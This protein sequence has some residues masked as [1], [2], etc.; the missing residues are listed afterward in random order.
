MK[1]LIS[2]IS[3]LV[4]ILSL[5]ACSGGGGGS[6]SKAIDGEWVNKNDEVTETLTIDDDNAL[7]ELRW[8]SPMKGT[9][10]REEQKITFKD[11]SNNS[12]VCTYEIVGEKLV[13][14]SDNMRTISFERED[15]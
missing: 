15:E 3:I 14:E 1:K 6:S 8:S 7:I 2:L 5:T 11:S 12:I 4:L 9:V 10:D 13:L